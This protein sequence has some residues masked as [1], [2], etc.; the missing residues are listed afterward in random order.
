MKIK[1][2]V[3]LKHHQTLEYDV[4]SWEWKLKKKLK[5]KIKNAKVCGEKDFAANEFNDRGT[6]ERGAAMSKVR[7]WA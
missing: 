6:R 7:P 4:C 1:S 3:L 2:S 5:W